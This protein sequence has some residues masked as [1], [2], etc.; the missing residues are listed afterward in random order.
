MDK[1]TQTIQFQKRP[2]VLGY[3]SIAGK[4]EGQGP[5][6]K[7][8][9]QVMP[10]ALWGEDSWEKTERK[11]FSYAISQACRRAGIKIED[12]SVLFGGDLLNQIISASFSARDLH[13]CFFGQYGACSTMAQSLFLGGM[14]VDGGY[15][16]RVACGASSH[17]PTA[18]RQYRFPLELGCQRPPTAQRTVTGAGCALLG[19]AKMPKI[20]LTCGTVGRIVDW[21]VT[22]ANNMG[23]VM[24][25]AAANTL[26]VHFQNTGTSPNDY[27][28]ILSGDLGWFGQKLCREIMEKDYGIK[29]GNNYTDCGCEIYT[30]D[31]EVDSGGSGCGCSAS[32]LNSYIFKGMEQG[33]WKRVLFMATGAMLSPT[34]AMQNDTI[35][36][37]AHAVVLERGEQA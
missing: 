34:S 1:K 28:L 36:G 5:L 3:G 32:V 8:F 17:F 19:N 33:K 30:K 7:E 4:I 20:M 11:M 6:G 14:C 16:D 37:I 10:D 2:A 26:A 21:E 24:A 22:D 12:I 15:F 18:E 9:D 13:L 25:P 23:A 31:M 27:D 35:P 29:L